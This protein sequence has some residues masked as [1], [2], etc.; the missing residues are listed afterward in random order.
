MSIFKICGGCDRHVVLGDGVP[1]K[2]GDCRLPFQGI[3]DALV[4]G[5]CF[6]IRE[7]VPGCL[8]AVLVGCL[9]VGRKLLS[10]ELS[11]HFAARESTRES[12]PLASVIFT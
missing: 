9:L 10:C 6:K 11:P 2:I 12:W 7:C 1:G 3:F 5:R 4:R 8:D